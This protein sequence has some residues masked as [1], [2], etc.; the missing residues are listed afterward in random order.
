MF[1]APA[2]PKRPPPAAGVVVVAVVDCPNR[3]PVAGFCAALPKRDMVPVAPGAVVVLAVGVE[4]VEEPKR[5]PAA[6]G[7]EAA[8]PL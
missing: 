4:V 3:P 8:V 1:V 2:A 6:E 7:L 5:L